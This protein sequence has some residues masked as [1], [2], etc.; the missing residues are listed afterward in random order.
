MPNILRLSPHYTE[1]FGIVKDFLWPRGTLMAAAELYAKSFAPILRASELIIHHSAFAC[2][3]G[4]HDLCSGRFRPASSTIVPSISAKT[5]AGKTIS[6]VRKFLVQFFSGHGSLHGI[7]APSGPFDG[8]LFGK[9]E[10]DVTNLFVFKAGLCLQPC[11][12]STTG[13]P[14]N[15]TENLFSRCHLGPAPPGLFLP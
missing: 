10:D 11:N 1:F 2:P 13:R 4:R 6:A 5:A 7:D 15:D 12:I 8:P 14:L 3:G 9:P